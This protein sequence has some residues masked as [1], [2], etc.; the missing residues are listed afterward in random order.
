MTTEYFTLAASVFGALTAT[1][2][3]ITSIANAWSGKQRDKRIQEIHISL[4]SEL[5]DL[6]ALIAKDSR[7]EGV[8]EGRADEKANPSK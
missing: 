1:L 3:M 5:K 2:A 8:I 7:A 4:N 6:K